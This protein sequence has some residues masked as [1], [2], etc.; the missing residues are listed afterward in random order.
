MDNLI[1]T[2]NAVIPLFLMMALGYIFREKKLLQNNFMEVFNR[3]C[4]EFA[5]PCSLFKTALSSNIRET[6]DINLAFA[7]IG[8]ILV[9]V[10]LLLLLIPRFFKDR[11]KAGSLI[12]GAFRANSIIFG[13]A[14]GRNL[15]GEAE[16]APITIMVTLSVPTFNFLAVLVLSLFSETNKNPSPL[17]LIK[18]VISNKLILVSILGIVMSYFQVTLPTIVMSPI[19]D[20]AAASGPLAMMALGA[21]FSFS[22]A[23]SNFIYNAVAVSLRLVVTP[24]IMV[25]AMCL[26]GYRGP[27]LGGLFILFAS[28]TATTTYVMANKMGCDSELA[29][30]IVVFSTF[31]SVITIFT[32]VYLLR[33]LSMI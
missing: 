32:G 24:L 29:G 9:Q 6:F 7:V 13:L 28:P 25:T 3:F 31:F 1:F 5:L 19:N 21:S 15:F 33:S 10:S 27:A 26:I 14:L 2:I 30:E 18:T 17:D 20:L 22:R 16:L 11:P 4:F 8:G 23:K 12:Q